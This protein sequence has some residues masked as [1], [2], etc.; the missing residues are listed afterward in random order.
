LRDAIPAKKPQVSLETTSILLD[1]S[2]KPDP[3][4]PDPDKH[5]RLTAHEKTAVPGD[6]LT[7]GNR[8]T[9]NGLFSAAFSTTKTVTPPW[10]DVTL[11]LTITSAANFAPPQ[12]PPNAPAP[13]ITIDETKLRDVMILSTLKIA[14]S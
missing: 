5:F 11:V 3:D 8:D 13:A 6:P 12:P 14:A 7:F 4:D 1:A 10:A 9:D 2:E